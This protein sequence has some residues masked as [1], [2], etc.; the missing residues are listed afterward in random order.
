[1]DLDAYPAWRYFPSHKRP[2]EWIE[3]LVG[4]FHHARESIDSAVERDPRVTS[5]MALAHLRGDLLKLG[6]EVEAGKKADQK[7]H[8]PVLFGEFGREDMRYEVDAFHPGY[9]IALEVEAGRGAM[10]NAVY[11]DIIQT[12]LLVDARF[13]ALAVMNTYRFKTGGKVTTTRSYRDTTNLLEAIYASTR[14]ALPF[15]GV[16]L[17]GY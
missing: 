13:F 5:D 14:L 16:L 2:P 17:I 11:R 4:A 12:S 9:E 1:M 10:G 7:L 6:F 15:D 3:G 8:R